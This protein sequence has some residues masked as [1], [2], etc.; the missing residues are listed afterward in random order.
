[1]RLL[2]FLVWVAI[3]FCLFLSGCRASIRAADLEA[4]IELRTTPFD[5]VAV[6]QVDN[7]TSRVGHK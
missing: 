6:K 5:V 2:L 3:G 7:D 4:S 1:M